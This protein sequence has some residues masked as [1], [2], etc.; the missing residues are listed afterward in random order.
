[1]VKPLTWQNVSQVYSQAYHLHANQ[2]ILNDF[3]IEEQA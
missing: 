2:R 1:M 3:V